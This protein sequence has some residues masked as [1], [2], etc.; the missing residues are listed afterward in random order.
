VGQFEC[1]SLKT[2]CPLENEMSVRH[3]G[4][5]TEPRAIF[6]PVKKPSPD[7]GWRVEATWP[8]GQTEK[9]GFFPTEDEAIQWIASDSERWAGNS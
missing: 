2:T 4:G 9:I 7:I 1:G 3:I 5:M 8:N 6:V